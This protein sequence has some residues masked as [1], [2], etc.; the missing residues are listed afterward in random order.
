MRLFVTTLMFAIAA[1]AFAQVLETDNSP[2]AV[3]EI[4]S[5]ESNLSN[6]IVHGDW[7]EFSKFLAADYVRTIADGRSETRDQ[8][9]AT[10]R[11]GE[12]RILAMIPEELEVR[13]YGDT[14]IVTGNLTLT[15]RL[16]NRVREKRNRFTDVFIRRSGRWFLAATQ[17]TPAAPVGKR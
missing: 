10:L 1:V 7:D 13:L 8:T 4:R 6:L 9:M 3:D 14:A 17:I 12:P 2:E 5:L 11:S 15:A 16:E